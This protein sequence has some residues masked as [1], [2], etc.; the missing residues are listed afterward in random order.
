MNALIPLLFQLATSESLYIKRCTEMVLRN[1]SAYLIE[2]LPQNGVTPSR[3]PAVLRARAE[4][5]C[6]NLYQLTHRPAAQ[7]P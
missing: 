4:Q 7:P 6:R 3:N 1:P 5:H 2:P